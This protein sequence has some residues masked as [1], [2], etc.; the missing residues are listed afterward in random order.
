MK[1]IELAKINSTEYKNL[2]KR[3]GIN[4]ENAYQ[5]VIPILDKIKNEGEKAVLNY[6]KMYDG[7]E[8]DNLLVD[9]D[10]I[11]ESEHY[12]SEELKNAIATAVNNITKFHELQLP[13]TYEIETMR[14][15]QC[16]RIF[17]PIENVGLYI[18]GGS[19]TLFSTLLMLAI[20]A[21]LAGCKSNR[22]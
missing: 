13:R 1:N 22:R 6:A 11:Q 8:E 7:I 3:P 14:G 15:V 2:L 18:P 16:G 17:R 9:K 12:I 5:T 20:P 19:A 10:E 21:K 4:F